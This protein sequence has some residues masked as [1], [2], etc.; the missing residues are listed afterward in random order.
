MSPT[1]FAL[2][3]KWLHLLIHDLNKLIILKLLMKKK[4]LM[5][6]KFS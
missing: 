6:D 1:I 2:L 5:L 3:S 4:N